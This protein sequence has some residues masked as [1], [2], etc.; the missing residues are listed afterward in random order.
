MAQVPKLAEINKAV[1]EV[2]YTEEVA[3]LYVTG[4]LALMGTC[5]EELEKIADHLIQK[6]LCEEDP[7]IAYK[8]LHDKETGD[9]TRYLKIIW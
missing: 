9:F 1:D 2:K 3:V 4:R 5:K 6:G 7:E 8:W